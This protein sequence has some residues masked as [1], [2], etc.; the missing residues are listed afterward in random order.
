M[1][2]S[3]QVTSSLSAAARCALLC[4]VASSAALVFGGAALAAQTNHTIYAFGNQSG[5][6]AL[7]ASPE[8]D[9]E[10]P[11]GTLNFVPTVGRIFGATAAGRHSS[12]GAFSAHHP[13][14]RRW[15][16]RSS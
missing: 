1:S 7:P 14:P 5:E 9:G 13:R 15:R 8:D 6:F 2:G 12:I 3:A 11:K 10:F 4:V 16:Q